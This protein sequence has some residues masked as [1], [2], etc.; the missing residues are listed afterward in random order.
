MSEYPYKHIYISVAEAE[1]LGLPRRISG[2]TT[3]EDGRIFQN[4]YYRVRKDK[5]YKSEPLEMWV[6]SNTLKISKERKKKNKQKTAKRNQKLIKR[7]KLK[8]GCSVCGY[9]KCADAL[10][11]HHVVKEDKQKEISTMAQYSSKAI[12]EEIRKC[13]IYCANCH[14]EHHYNERKDTA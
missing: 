6:N 11:Y 9:N 13:V 10:H 5:G 7:I 8:F 14:A 1:S 4:Y 2:R 3:R 12:K